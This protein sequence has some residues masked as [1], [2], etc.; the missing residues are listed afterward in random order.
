MHA[1]TLSPLTVRQ[2]PRRE[3]TGRESAL[4]KDKGNALNVAFALPTGAPARLELLDLS[5]RLV[6]VR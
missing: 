2:H 1:R 4:R 3:G 5:G 6:L